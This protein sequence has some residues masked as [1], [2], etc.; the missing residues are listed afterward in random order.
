[1][2]KARTYTISEMAAE[3]GVTLRTLRFYEGRE[4]VAPARTRERQRIY[5]EADRERF[6]RI[7]TWAEQG[8]T[9]REI[10]HALN[11]GGFDQQQLVKQIELLREQRANTD[12]AIAELEQQVAA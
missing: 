3:F 9:L 10:K 1:M 7:H 2:E 4:L 12:R 6:R 5:S 8:F 11:F